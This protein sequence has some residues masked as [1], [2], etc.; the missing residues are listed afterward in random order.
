MGGTLDL[1]IEKAQNWAGK[2][3]WLYVQMSPAICLLDIWTS[4]CS[5]GESAPPHPPPGAL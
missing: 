5:P 1:V 4:H 2:K 3:G